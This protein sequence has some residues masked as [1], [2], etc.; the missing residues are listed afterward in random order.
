[1]DFPP[2]CQP[3]GRVENSCAANVYR[4]RVNGFYRLTGD[5][6]GWRIQGNKLIGPNG[7]QFTPQTLAHAWRTFSLPE[8]AE[9]FT[10]AKHGTTV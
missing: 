4:Q 2:C 9:I 8:S 10:V 6:T 5:W 1:M 7:L 3:T